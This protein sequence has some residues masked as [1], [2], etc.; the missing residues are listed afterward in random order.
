MAIKQK[1]LQGLLERIENDLAFR[2]TMFAGTARQSSRGRTAK[3]M[4]AIHVT[5]AR[6]R[7]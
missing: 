2:P 5:L 6:A 3:L 1:L 7:A 4:M